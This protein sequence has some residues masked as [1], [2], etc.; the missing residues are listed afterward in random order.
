MKQYKFALRFSNMKRYFLTFILLIVVGVVKAQTVD[1]QAEIDAL[2]ERIAKLE[3]RSAVWD[4]L[5]PAFKLSGYLQAGY[6]YLW[7]EDG[8]QTSTFHLRRARVSLQGDIYNGKKGAKASYRIQIDLCKELPIM[9][10][11]AKYQPVNQFGVQA[12]QFKVPVSIENTDYAATKLEFI[13]YSLPVQRLARLSS[14]DLQG[15]NSSG[16]DIGAM[17]Y[18][19]FIKRDGFSIINYELGVFNGTGINVKDNNKSKDIAARLT[20][21]P[22]KDLKIAAYYMGGETNATS[23]VTKYPAMVL[24]NSAVNLSYLDYNRYGG[25]FDYENKYIF[26][27]AEY[28]GGCTGD[29]LSSGVY[30]LVGYKFLGKCS[31]GVRYA[32]LDEN[33]NGESTTPVQSDYSV[34]LSYHPWK[35]LRLQAEYTRQV[36]ENLPDVVASSDIKKSQNCLYLMVTALF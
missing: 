33:L 2:N 7:T 31:V 13:T 8:T 30:A 22:L 15:V 36:Y 4:K 20:I 29:Y 18:G 21:Q 10:L 1:Q 28:L 12:G 5:K 9:D 27:R 26:A 25:G 17:L 24:D 19:G 3:K 16:R 11:W 23:L 34:A 32:Y 14:S 6:D 35:H